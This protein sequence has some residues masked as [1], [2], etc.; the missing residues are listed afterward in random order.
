MIHDRITD[1]FDARGLDPYWRLVHCAD[2]NDGGASGSTY[3][4]TGWPSGHFMEQDW[5][6]GHAT[7]IRDDA[8]N[9]SGKGVGFS[10][11]AETGGSQN[12]LFATRNRLDKTALEYYG[13]KEHG[14]FV[15][16]F[17]VPTGLCM[18]RTSGNA[19]YFTSMLW[20]AYDGTNQHIAFFN[21]S[22][23]NVGIKLRHVQANAWSNVLPDVSLDMGGWMQAGTWHKA[24]VIWLMQ[25]VGGFVRLTIDDVFTL[26]ATGNA[27]LNLG[28]GNLRLFAQG[29]AG[30]ISSNSDL[31]YFGRS[32]GY[33]LYSPTGNVWRPG[34]WTPL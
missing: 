5:H 17:R 21:T 30:S 27:S 33:K 32:D 20:T 29:P 1:P 16:W 19:Y 9:W 11:Q 28:S 18:F 26:M 8:M 10:T 22:G 3:L 24:E 4:S 25:A 14:R 13:V 2:F 12:S 23:N 6:P 7:K 15:W 31:Q 34:L